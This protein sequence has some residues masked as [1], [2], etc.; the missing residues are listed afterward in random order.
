MILISKK[1]LALLAVFIIR[2][3][4][5]FSEELSWEE[6]LSEAKS[7]NPAL[8]QARQAVKAAK[9][10]Y[11]RSYSAFLPSLSAN[12]ASNQGESDSSGF[13][14]DY[15]YGLSASLTL[16]SGF[17]DIA[18]A[19]S[20]DCDLKLAELA[21]S[22]ALSDVE[23]NLKKSYVN[24]QWAQETVRL[25][26]E[27]LKRRTENYEMIK[28]KYEAGSE[29]RGSLLR[30]EADKS[31]AEF[32]LSKAKRA[33]SSAS[34]QLVKAMG[35]DGFEGV[36]AKDKLPETPPARVVAVEEAVKKI[37]EYNMAGYALAK[38]SLSRVSARGG[39]WP[40]ITATAS[41]SKSG[42]EWPPETNRWNAGI[43]ISYSFFPGGRNIFDVNIAD[44]N[45]SIAEASFKET[46]QQLSVK[47]DSAVNAYL[48]SMEN[49]KVREKFLTASREQ[50][51]ITTAKYINGLASY[52]DW[53]VIE[54]D[55][56]ASQR[57]MLNAKRDAHL[58]KAGL[59]NTLGLGD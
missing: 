50:S 8:A 43:N 17:A 21:Y 22:R 34:L 48:D 32:D 46:T 40:D 44:I 2:V 33:L 20:R 58:S 1:T 27:I 57:S 6:A 35:R 24:L 16:F 59:D 52:Q 37:P 28:L 4:A 38:A 29:D 15:S 56:I 31:Q 19:R 7:L 41:K 14:K 36:T 10:Y 30:I 39:L 5:L 54:N 12:A 49:I 23:Y 9:Q 53:Y 55:Y 3:P 45:K 47:L 13:S 26:E 11:F 25:S 51:D 42:A 18:E